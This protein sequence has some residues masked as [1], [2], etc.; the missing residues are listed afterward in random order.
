MKCDPICEAKK[1]HVYVSMCLRLLCDYREDFW[2]YKNHFQWLPSGR[3]IEKM[4]LKRKELTFGKENSCDKPDPP[5]PHGKAR[6]GMMISGKPSFLA[7]TVVL[8]TRCG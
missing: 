6:P 3:E 8:S 5:L 1:V 7:T 2:I 4:Q